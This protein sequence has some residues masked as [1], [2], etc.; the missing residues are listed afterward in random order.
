ML[1]CVLGDKQKQWNA[2][3]P[4]IEFSFNNM[5]NQSTGRSFFEIVYARPPQLALDLV[6]PPKS[7]GM[8]MVAESLAERI[9][10]IQA[11]ARDK[12]QQTNKK[13]K[14]A[15]NKH[16]QAKTFQEGDLVM[17]HL[18]KN[19][20]PAGTYSKLQDRKYGLSHFKEN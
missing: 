8:S 18:C 9:Q 7:P 2:N 6:S 1:R 17:I 20:L 14:Q 10:S 19:R 4:Q 11:D 12:V 13:Y 15:A 3:L 5:P 16:R